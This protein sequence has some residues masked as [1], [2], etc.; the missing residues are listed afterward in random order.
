MKT[1]FIVAMLA[2]I[3]AAGSRF[4]ADRSLRLAHVS[5]IFILVRVD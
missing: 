4:N 1:L 3:G 5:R 2:L